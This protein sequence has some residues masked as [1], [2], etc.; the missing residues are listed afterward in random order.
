[1]IVLVLPDCACRMSKAQSL[2]IE[3]KLSK[4]PRKPN[5]GGPL[6]LF[7]NGEC[8]SEIS[9]MHSAILQMENVYSIITKVEKKTSELTI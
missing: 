4:S 7:D 8:V 9:N 6:Q 2:I 3:N 5:F 1:M